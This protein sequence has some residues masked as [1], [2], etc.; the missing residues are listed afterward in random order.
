MR[1][2][3]QQLSAP[4]VSGGLGPGSGCELEGLP[5]GLGQHTWTTGLCRERKQQAMKRVLFTQAHIIACRLQEL[6]DLLPS[7]GTSASWASC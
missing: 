2:I 5:W 3:L 7:P 4:G 6:T 1:W